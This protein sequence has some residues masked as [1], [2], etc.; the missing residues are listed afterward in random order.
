MSAM[1]WVAFALLSICA[2]AAAFYLYRRREPAGRGRNALA[3]LRACAVILLLLLIFDPRV[4]QPVKSDASNHA[5]VLLDASLSMMMPSN[6]GATEWNDAVK[7]ATQRANGGA[8]TTFGNAIEN[9]NADSISKRT[10]DATHSNLLPA[11]QSASESG[12]D[13]VTI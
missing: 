6:A 5:P 3:A 13:A 2:I 8:I 11:L 1:R 10:P 9:V 4:R 12:A 7:Q